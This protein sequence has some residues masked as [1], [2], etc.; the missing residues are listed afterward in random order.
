MRRMSVMNYDISTRVTAM[1]V[2]NNSSWFADQQLYDRHR[3]KNTPALVK[4]DIK[5]TAPGSAQPGPTQSWAQVGH[6][7]GTLGHTRL[8]QGGHKPRGQCVSAD[9]ALGWLGSVGHC[10][11]SLCTSWYHKGNTAMNVGWR[12]KDT[13]NRHGNS[14]QVKWGNRDLRTESETC[15]CNKC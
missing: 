1:M 12:L 5:V 8:A 9:N 15:W 11:G 10:S 3:D 14:L 7:V 4:A 6:V 13:K 2:T